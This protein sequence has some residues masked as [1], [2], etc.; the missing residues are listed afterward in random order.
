MPA[1]AIVVKIHGRGH[2]AWD[3]IAIHKSMND[4]AGEFQFGGVDFHPGRPADWQINMGDLCLVDI[5]DQQVANGYLDLIDRQQSRRDH[6]FQIAGRD[7]TAD[8]VDCSHYGAATEWKKK[9]IT[10]LV[11]TLCAPFGIPVRVDASATAR[12]A[13]IIESFKADEG[14]LVYELIARLCRDNSLLPL[15]YGDGYLTLTNVSTQRKA[16]DALQ[17]DINILTRRIIHSDRNRY[18]RYLVKG[19]GIGNDNK[20]LAVITEPYGMVTDS[21]IRRYRPL[22]TLAESAVNSAQCRDRARW[23][24]R[25]RAGFSRS[26]FCEVDGWLQTNGDVWDINMEVPVYDEAMSVDERMLISE[27]SYIRDRTRE[28]TKMTLVNK[29]TYDVLTTDNLIKGGFDA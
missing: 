23:E 3:D 27:V 29:E 4:I 25:I 12:T 6:N 5:A 18:S 11:T 17:A 28:V 24:A 22:I 16:H 20:S 1:T 13:T 15:S 26:Y 9:S 10:S 19:Q 8:L 14:D 7:V 21:V 2:A